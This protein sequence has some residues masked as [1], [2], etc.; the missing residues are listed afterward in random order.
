MTAFKEA[1]TRR[2]GYAID[3]IVAENEDSFQELS[4]YQ[5][6]LNSLGEL[7]QARIVVD[8]ALD[9]GCGALEKN[10]CSLW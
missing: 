1:T 3:E 8:V 5:K 6:K 10:D 4:N 2:F 9:V 7:E